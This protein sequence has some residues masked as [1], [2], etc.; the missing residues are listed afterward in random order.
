MPSKSVRIGQLIAP[1]GPGSIYTDRMGI[2]HVVCGLD[3]W[4]SRY[5]IDTG[6]QVSM[7]AQE[8]ERFEPRLSALLGVDRFR[9]PPDYRPAVTGATAPPNTDLRI[10]AQR[11]PTWY[12]NTRTGEMR[13]FNLHTQRIEIPPDGGRFRPVRFIAVC[14]AGHLCEFPWKAWIGCSCE[15]DGKLVLTDRGGSELSSIYVKCLSCPPE[16]RGS[17]GRTLSGTTS[18]GEG[19]QDGQSAFQR[20]GIACPGERP[21]LGHGAEEDG[22]ARSL[23][24]ALINQTNLYFPRVISAITLPSSDSTTK[25]QRQLTAEVEKEQS[26]LGPAKTIWKLGNR[27]GATALIKVGLDRRGIAMETSVLQEILENIFDKNGGNAAVNET[28]PVEP[29]SQLLRFRRAEY[30]IIRN[31]VSDPVLNANLHVVPTAVPSVLSPFLQRVNLVE[32]LREIRTFFGFDRLKQEENDFAQMP[33]TAMR[34]LFRNPPMDPVDRWL[35]AVEVFGEGIYVE[36]HEEELRKWQDQNSG[37][38]AQRLDDAFISRLSEIHQCIPPEG[39]AS[40]LWASRYLLVHSLAHILITE[41][42]F[43]SGYG[44]AS[45]RERLFVSADAVAPMAAFMIYTAAGDAEG[46]LGGLVRL[47]RCDRLGTVVTRALS[48]ASW[49]SADPVCSENLGGNGARLANLAACHSC[50]LL[51]ETSCE[52]INQGLDRAMI[53]GMPTNRNAGFMAPLIEMAVEM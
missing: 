7:Q 47:G 14:S 53:V 36:L 10:P 29:E 31:H 40:R 46:T 20:A 49:C 17:K 44:S 5:T 48:R 41:L 50:V 15:G 37:W 24:G 43:E 3:H 16:S 21:W 13:R 22:C 2:P 51:P 35:P 8:F 11:F 9:I 34:Q 27:E 52:T 25:T 19:S 28:P 6:F 42:V 18:T 4:Y 39:G 1:F 12:R 30:N 26:T 32:R 33:E 45:L 38:L 23:I